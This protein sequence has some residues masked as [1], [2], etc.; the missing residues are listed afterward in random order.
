M[1]EYQDYLKEF[2]RYS[3]KP[4][5]SYD[6][7]RTVLA[8]CSYFCFSCRKALCYTPLFEWFFWSF[9]SQEAFTS[10]NK[11]KNPSTASFK[12]VDGLCVYEYNENQRM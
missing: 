10:R 11:N 2:I 3:I 8:A 4:Y 5:G 12:A 1:K 7:K 9:I 6:F